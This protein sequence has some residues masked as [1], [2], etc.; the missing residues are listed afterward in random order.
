MNER[1]GVKDTTRMNNYILKKIIETGTTSYVYKGVDLQTN[2]TVAIKVINRKKYIGIEK[3][4]ARENRILREALI[5]FLLSHKSI[6]RLREF[7]YNNECFY[8]VFEYVPGEQLLKKV[9]KHKK[10]AEGL[11]K[12][13]FVQVLNAL[14]YCHMYNIVHRDIKIEN[15]LIDKNDN[16]VLID[17]GLANFYE[18]EGFLGTFCGSLYFAAPELLSGNL[19]KGPEVD[20]WSL[21]VV[22]YVMICG[23]VP[24]DDKNLQSLYHKIKEG[25]VI[26]EEISDELKSLLVQMLNPNRKTRI[27]IEEIRSHPW[28]KGDL[29]LMESIDKRTETEQAD[30]KIL[31]YLNYLFGGQFKKK[32]GSYYNSIKKLYI[33]YKNKQKGRWFSDRLDGIVD[34]VSDKKLKVKNS[35]VRHWRG[36]KGSEESLVGAIEEIIREMGIIFEVVSGKYICTLENSDTFVVQLSKNVFNKAYGLDIK[37]RSKTSAMKMIKKSMKSRLKQII[38]PDNLVLI[39]G[40][41]AL[42]PK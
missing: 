23:R 30:P 4:S 20:V 15:I 42:L 36:V 32:D 34:F 29:R 38:H 26:T 13:Y 27:T 25:A 24:F 12:K 7:F 19:Y 11:A 1:A 39:N 37:S 2:E 8:L 33:L 41:N 31:E 35:L 3:K 18:K 22:L 10:I 16:A 17:F 9:V 6:P 28:V 5:S 40:A 14:H 21:G